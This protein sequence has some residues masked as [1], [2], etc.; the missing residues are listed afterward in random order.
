[1]KLALW[2]R[3]T[4]LLGV[5]FL[6]RGPVHHYHNSPRLS[7]ILQ[8]VEYSSTNQSYLC[9]SCQNTHPARPS[10]GL[11]ICVSTSQ[12]HNFQQP[13]TPG[14]FCTPDSIHVDWVTIPG[15]VLSDLMQAWTIDYKRERS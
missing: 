2:L 10:Y 3:Y 4:N 5:T 6:T 1:M 15:A 13:R 14:V 9:P 8:R 11:N 12:L 7:R